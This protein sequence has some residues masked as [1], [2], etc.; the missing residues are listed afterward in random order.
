MA[1]AAQGDTVFAGGR[2]NGTIQESPVNGL[3]SYNV[4]SGSL[5]TQPPVLAGS[6]VVVSSIGV[7]PSSSDLYV[8]GSFDTA[9]S[10]PCPAV[11]MLDTGSN[12]WSRP[13]FELSGTVNTLLWSS[14]S[15]LF[16]GGQ[17]KIGDADVYLASYDV[18]KNKWSIFDGASDLPGP[19]DAITAA[20]K[21]RDKI[22]VAGTR[23]DGTV[24]LMKYDGRWTSA[25]ITLEPETV[26]ASLQMFSLT[27]NHDK[28]D[29]IDQGQAL[30]LTGSIGI[31]GFGTASGAIYNGTTLQPY[32]LT[33]SMNTTVGAG[34]LSKIFVEKE[35]F[36]QKS[37]SKYLSRRRIFLF[38]N[39]NRRIWFGPWFYR[40]YRSGH[41]PWP[42][43]AH[44]CCWSC[45][46]QVS[47]EAR[48]LHASPDVNDRSR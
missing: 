45:P 26:V 13:G 19:V 32:I 6:N 23:P 41:L 37:T 11:C 29:L 2:V 27:K 46:R 16:V 28:S 48:R 44:C 7:R 21:E 38:A 34:S 3:I 35:N 42:D 24:Y 15:M 8:G 43:A 9:G 12:Q 40:A 31:P 5:G 30:L 47:E 33:S 20:D 25:S 14:S 17:L 39:Y 10:L 18:S 1:L 36:F 4:A 22:W